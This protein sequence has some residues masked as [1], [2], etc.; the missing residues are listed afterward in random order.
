[1]IPRDPKELVERAREGSR[2]ALARLL[3]YVESGG[4]LQ[5]ATASLAYQVPAP[6]VVGLTGPPGAG[7][8]TL[9]DQLITTALAQGSSGRLAALCQ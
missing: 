8:S 9:T 3:T 5:L 2:P 7:K 6:Y 1:M 4:A